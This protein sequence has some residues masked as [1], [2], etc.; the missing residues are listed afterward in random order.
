[1]EGVKLEESVA[2]PHCERDGVKLADTHTV[3]LWLVVTEEVEEGEKEAECV[4]LTLLLAEALCEAV[5]HELI[6]ALSH[7][8]REGV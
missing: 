7:C 2:L 8:E 1:M 4:T 6:V 3:P 5:A